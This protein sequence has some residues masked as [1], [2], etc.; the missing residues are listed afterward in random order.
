MRKSCKFVCFSEER[1]HCFCFVFCCGFFGGL[2]FFFFHRE[3]KKTRIAFNY[4]VTPGGLHFSMPVSHWMLSEPLSWKLPFA[5]WWTLQILLQSCLSC[6][7]SIKHSKT[8]PYVLPSTSPCALQVVFSFSATRSVCILSEQCV[9][10]C[11]RIHVCVCSQCRIVMGGGGGKAHCLLSRSFFLAKKN[12]HICCFVHRAPTLIANSSS[13]FLIFRSLD[14]EILLSERMNN[15]F[16]P[17]SLLISKCHSILVS[18]QQ[19]LVMPQSLILWGEELPKCTK[20]RW[21][22]TTLD[23]F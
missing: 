17:F 5:C 6:Q 23:C 11:A 16:P 19:E 15:Y 12:S 2:L 3:G 18:W 13:D 20:E 1:A 21:R 22:E 4:P 10:M 8:A 7:G 14:T 9:C